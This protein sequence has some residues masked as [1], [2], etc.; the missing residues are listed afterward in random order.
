MVNFY[1]GTSDKTVKFEIR[2]ETAA[3]QLVS[4]Q[5]SSKEFA[6]AASSPVAGGYILNDG[7]CESSKEHPAYLNQ[8]GNASV[9][10]NNHFGHWQL[11]VYSVADGFWS[12][13]YY[14]ADDSTAPLPPLS[15]WRKPPGWLIDYESS[16]FAC[17]LDCCSAEGP[18]LSV[19]YGP[20]SG[21]E[22]GQDELNECLND[23]QTQQ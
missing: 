10:F 7:W 8:S 19:L 1:E 21:D 13:V 16:T 5:I 14:N 4:G 22:T 6:E 17:C 12:N 15:G 20:S 9:E 18:E 3:D 2:V 11:K 23:L